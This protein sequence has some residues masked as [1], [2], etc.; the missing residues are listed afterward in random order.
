[1]HAGRPAPPP[2]PNACPPASA[3]SSGPSTSEASARGAIPRLFQRHRRMHARAARATARTAAQHRPV[4]CS[5][6][7]IDQDTR[8]DRPCSHVMRAATATA[9][10]VMAQ[11][12]SQPNSQPEVRCGGRGACVEAGALPHACSTVPAAAA[13][14]AQATLK[15]LLGPPAASWADLRVLSKRAAGAGRPGSGV[16]AP[17]SAR[18]A[19]AAR[20][21]A[22]EA[23]RQADGGEGAG[24]DRGG[25]GVRSGGAVGGG[26][27]D[28]A[29]QGRLQGLLARLNERQRAAV[30][31]PA[32]SPLLV[33]AGPGSGK[34][35]AMIARVAFLMTQV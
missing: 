26:G 27:A 33:A 22:V 9:D 16:C 18:M 20:A 21:A 23:P 32:G 17:P 12:D 1:M 31:A 19:A 13:A 8:A 34:T 24:R 6:T 25:G 15:A 3:P 2:P 4:N 14:D 29:A 35:S 28:E 7:P 5:Q 30:L 10:Q 11:P